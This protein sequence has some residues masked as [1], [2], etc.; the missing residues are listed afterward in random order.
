MGKDLSCFDLICLR[1]DFTLEPGLES[2]GCLDQ[3]QIHD[4]SLF[5]YY[6]PFY[7]FMYLLMYVCGHRRATVGV[8]S[9]RN[10]GFGKGSQ[11][12]RP[13]SFSCQTSSLVLQI[14]LKNPHPRARQMRLFKVEH[15]SEQHKE[16]YENKD[17]LLWEEILQSVHL[18]GATLGTYQGMKQLD[19]KNPNIS[20][21]K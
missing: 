2:L 4:P 9:F 11:V 8:L 15:A 17:N 18:K 7:L 13:I 21:F 5:L 6:R 14:L 16:R 12:I 3:T 1:R 10:V 19:N 20:V